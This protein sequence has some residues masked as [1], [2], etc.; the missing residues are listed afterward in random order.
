MP[1]LRQIPRPE[2]AEGIVPVMY[3][4]IFGDRDPV[5]SPGLPNGTPGNWWTVVAQSPALLEHCVS[6]FAFYQSPD[7]EL[8]APLRE[9]SQLRVGWARASRFVFSQHCKAAR[10]HGVREDQIAAITSWQTSDAFDDAE[11]AVLGWTD[12]L[13]LQGGRASDGLFAALRRHL[14]EVAI[15]ELTYIACWYDLHAVMSRALRLELDDV[16]D[17]ITEL[18][19]DGIT[20]GLFTDAPDRS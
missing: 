11:R 9:L 14:S 12:A 5:A 18:T 3:D 4:F 1:R 15:L 19:G 8:P 16:E 13:V 17:P 7:R 10:D 2:A 20:S 6:G